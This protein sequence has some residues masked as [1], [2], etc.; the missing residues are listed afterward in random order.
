MS[1][2]HYVFRTKLVFRKEDEGFDF[3]EFEKKFENE[4]SIKA[5]RSAFKEYQN[6]LE[7]FLEAKNSHYYSD[8][9]QEKI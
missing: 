2:F 8:K 1:A 6:Y 5:R 9:K 3:F 7:T 4:N